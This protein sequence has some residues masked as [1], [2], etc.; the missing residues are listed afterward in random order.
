[1]LLQTEGKV[2]GPMMLIVAPTRELA[3][4]SQEVL[5][6]A[7]K[8]CNIRRN[9]RDCVSLDFPGHM[10]SSSIRNIAVR[11]WATYVA[12]ESKIGPITGAKEK[13]IGKQVGTIYANEKI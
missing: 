3:M 6:E 4:Q 12:G 1:M 8:S 9:D 5:E 13:G 10:Q 7:G 2:K 11:K